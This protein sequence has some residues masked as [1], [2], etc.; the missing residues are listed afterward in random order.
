MNQ[1]HLPIL[2]F[3][4]PSGSGKSELVKKIL[5]FFPENTTK[6]QQVTTRERRDHA[7]DYL[8]ITREQYSQLQASDMLT[9]QTFFNDNMYGTFPESVTNNV[10]VLTIADRVGLHSLITDV[11][12]HN[13][14]LGRGDSRGK[15]GT[16]PV[17]L[18]KVF[19]GYEVTDETVA[20]RGR[21]SRGSASI[22][23]EIL[24]FSDVTFDTFVDTTN[25]WPDV[26]EFFE[27]VVAPAIDPTDPNK[28]DYRVAINTMLEVLKTQVND[29]NASSEF[30]NRVY[31]ALNPLFPSLEAVTESVDVLMDS[32]DQ[33]LL[34]TSVSVEENDTAEAS[35]ETNHIEEP[36][37]TPLVEAAEISEE[38]P[39]EQSTQP[40]NTIATCAEISAQRDFLDWMSDEAIGID[41]FDN[42][43]NFKLYFSQYISSNHGNPNDINVSAQASRDGRG[44]KVIGYYAHMPNGEVYTVEFN[45]RLNRPVL[46]GMQK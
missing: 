20:K 30:L 10:A 5:S 2:V 23:A 35:I 14:A 44:G 21:S 24:K 27:S 42:T 28:E 18:T 40:S 8:F 6:W 32:V 11:E 19:V 37:Q 38:L 34:D 29:K 26:R 25:E 36:S 22:N 9:C 7:D 4:G 15:L 13:A 16:K 1:P 39:L 31:D 45:T 12:N 17:I 33:V 46:S 3:C 41:A 43:E